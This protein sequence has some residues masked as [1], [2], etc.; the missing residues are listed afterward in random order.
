MKSVG[1]LMSV[2]AILMM[3]CGA[4]VKS[5]QKPE[6]DQ[7]MNLTYAEGTA[8]GLIGGQAWTANYVEARKAAGDDPLRRQFRFYSSQPVDPI[9]SEPRSCDQMSW[10][11]DDKII[12]Y[13]ALAKVG[14]QGGGDGV[15]S[16]SAVSLLSF[17]YK[18]PGDGQFQ[19]QATDQ[20]KIRIDAVSAD[21]IQGA[22]AGRYDDANKISGTFVAKI[23]N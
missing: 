1:Y 20:V 5:K 14:E 10:A 23:C 6:G 18:N 13:S 12:S 8:S 9:T 22:I 2:V 11:K 19:N 21:V 7:E 15:G 3:S 16:G 17:S 4:N